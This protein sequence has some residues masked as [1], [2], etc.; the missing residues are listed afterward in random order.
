M[1]IVAVGAAFCMVAAPISTMGQQLCPCCM[2]VAAYVHEDFPTFTDA[3]SSTLRL[4]GLAMISMN[5]T[6]R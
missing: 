6:R 1:I 3:T 2:G 4:S 5:V